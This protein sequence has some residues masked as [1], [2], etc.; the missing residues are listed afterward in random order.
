VSSSGVLYARATHSKVFDRRSCHRVLF[1]LYFF[2]SVSLT[3]VVWQMLILCGIRR[4]VHDGVINRESSIV[5]AGRI[6]VVGMRRQ[7][8]NGAAHLDWP[9]VC[10]PD[11]SLVH[12]F[13]HRLKKRY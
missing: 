4:H 8:A 12:T 1:A 7:G 6:G 13:L 5:V 9:V 2:R 3:L 10:R 11:F